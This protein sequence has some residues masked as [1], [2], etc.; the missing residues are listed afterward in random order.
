MIFFFRLSSSTAFSIWQPKNARQT[1]GDKLVCI[2]N[3]Q[4]YPPERANS[5]DEARRTKTGTQQT[6]RMKVLKPLAVGYIG[7][8]AGNILYVLRIDETH[9]YPAGLEALIHGYPVH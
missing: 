8:P 9:L 2:W 7:F 4:H 6:H 5:A 1:V 3:L